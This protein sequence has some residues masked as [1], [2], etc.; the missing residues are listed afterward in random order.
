[1]PGVQ[2][3]PK[4]VKP[5]EDV[6]IWPVPWIWRK[7]RWIKPGPWEQSYTNHETDVVPAPE[8]ELGLLKPDYLR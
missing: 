8:Q 5:W 2:D 1:M 3:A 7:H 4:Q 6:G